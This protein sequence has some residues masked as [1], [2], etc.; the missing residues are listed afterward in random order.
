MVSYTT[1]VDAAAAD[2][3]NNKNFLNFLKIT[4][5]MITRFKMKLKYNVYV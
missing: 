5:I 3:I 1:F 4:I 2:D